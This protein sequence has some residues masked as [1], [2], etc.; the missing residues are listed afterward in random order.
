MEKEQIVK[1]MPVSMKTAQMKEPTEVGILAD[2]Y[3]VEDKGYGD[4]IY[5]VEFPETG[6]IRYAFRDELI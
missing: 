4:T 2:W 1:G 3:S 5:R 6:K